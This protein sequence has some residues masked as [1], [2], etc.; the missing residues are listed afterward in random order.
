MQVPTEIFVWLCEDSPCYG[1]QTEARM[2]VVSVAPPKFGPH[3]L[4]I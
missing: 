4:K 3:I 1:G 2:H